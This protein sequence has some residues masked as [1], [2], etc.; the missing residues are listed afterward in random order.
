MLHFLCRFLGPHIDTPIYLCLTVLGPGG[1]GMAEK[2]FRMLPYLQTRSL[3][4]GWIQGRELGHC[5]SVNGLGNIYQELCLIMLLIAKERRTW[6]WLLR[7]CGCWSHLC[8]WAH[9]QYREARSRNHCWREELRRG[10]PHLSLLSFSFFIPPPPPFFSSILP[11]F[12]LSYL[13]RVTLCRAGWS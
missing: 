7:V 12:L 10:P 8:P 5:L 9:L 1:R 4:K 6:Y 2:T 11:P 3:P 13:F